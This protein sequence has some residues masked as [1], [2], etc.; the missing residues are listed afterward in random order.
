MCDRLTVAEE[1][2][3]ISIP[4]IC[5][6]MLP[7][8]QSFF[9]LAYFLFFIFT[10]MSSQSCVHLSLS[11]VS[12]CSVSPVTPSSGSES[13]VSPLGS[14]GRPKFLPNSS[15][16][17]ESSASVSSHYPKAPGFEREDQVHGATH[18]RHVTGALLIL[19]PFSFL[20]VSILFLSFPLSAVIPPPSRELCNK[21]RRSRAVHFGGVWWILHVFWALIV[22]RSK[23]RDL[24]R[25][26]PILC[27]LV[28]L[29]L[30]FCKHI[31][32]I[33]CVLHH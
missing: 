4:I 1:R 28:L 32:N 15:L 13:V 14:S 21:L 22:Q 7:P 27:N 25:K 12:C 16:C 11:Q 17:L 30:L 31:M 8:V 9:S 24:I 26:Q 5:Y 33:I 18:A 23:P 20:F 6:P 19:L 10:I 3:F 29:L 2:G